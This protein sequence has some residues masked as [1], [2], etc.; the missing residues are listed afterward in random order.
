MMQCSWIS[1][2]G[3]QQYS[4]ICIALVLLNLDV[5]I[6]FPHNFCFQGSAANLGMLGTDIWGVEMLQVKADGISHHLPAS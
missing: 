5:S 6:A 2:L 4:R 3:Q 1:S